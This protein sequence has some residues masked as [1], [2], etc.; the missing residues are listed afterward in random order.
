[1]DDTIIVR[2]NESIIPEDM[3]NPIW[4]ITFIGLSIR[5]P[6]PAAV[7]IEW[8]Q[9]LESVRLSDL[10]TSGM[11]GPVGSTGESRLDLSA[12][13]VAL[14][15]AEW[16]HAVVVD[17]RRW[18]DPWAGLSLSLAAWRRAGGIGGLTSPD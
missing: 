5:L 16:R 6:K 7:V 12:Y 17:A 4:L 15:V 10:L 18:I 9:R 11:R 14:G 1:M 8:A 3:I 13:Q 2:K